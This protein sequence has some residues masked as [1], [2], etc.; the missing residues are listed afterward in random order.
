MNFLQL[1]NRFRQ[2]VNYDTSGPTTVTGQTGDH[3]RAVDWVSTAYTEIQNRHRWRWLRKG[4]TITTSSGNDTYGY[5]SAIDTSSGVAISRFKSWHVEDPYNPAKCYLSS[6]GS[7]SESWLN[8]LPWSQLNSLY[9]IGNQTDSQPAFITVDPNDDIVL[10][11]QPDGV[12]VVTGEYEKSAQVLAA[13]SDV[14]EMPSDYHMLIVYMA[15]EDYG[16]YDSANEI[17][18]RS[19][20]KGRRLMRQLE[21]TQLPKIRKVG[22]MV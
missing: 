2:E 11:P 9:N 16:F 20:K 8:Y 15:M 13:D 21:N 3:A 4:F 12:Y 5:T 6:A 17:L 1:V 18:S 7:G 22:P 14:P 10:G 19:A